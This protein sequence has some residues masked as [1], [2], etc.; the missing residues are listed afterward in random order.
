MAVMAYT[1][2]GYIVM[3]YAV[4]AYTVIGYIVMAYTVMAYIVMAYTVMADIVIAHIVTAYI[5][6]ASMFPPR[7]PVHNTFMHTPCAPVYTHLR[8]HVDAQAKSARE[9]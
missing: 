1:V 3:A 8:T 2:V 6:M 4:M 9:S 5:A 7:M